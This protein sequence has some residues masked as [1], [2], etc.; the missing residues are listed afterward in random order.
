MRGLHSVRKHVCALGVLAALACVIAVP[1]GAVASGS[2]HAYANLT[3]AER[4][5]A[6]V[7]KA[8]MATF[9]H[10]VDPA[11]APL[12]KLSGK[13]TITQI[14]TAVTGAAKAWSSAIKPVLALKAPAQVSRL[15]VQF[16]GYLRAGNTD[17]LGMEHSART[18]NENGYLQSARRLQT[19]VGQVISTAATLAKTLGIS[20]AALAF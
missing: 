11:F 18:G 6:K 19:D 9:A 20:L 14:V 4:T 15:V 2:P 10:A 7:F 1:T 17:L 3:S 13:S 16:Q 12:G 8:D 5:F